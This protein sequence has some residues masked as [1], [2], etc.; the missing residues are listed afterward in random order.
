MA[1]FSL[2]RHDVQA[3]VA[4]VLS[5]AAIPCLL[6][7]MFFVLRPLDVNQRI[8]PYNA[9]GMRP[10]AVYVSALAALSLSAAG[11]GFGLNSVGQRRNDKPGRSW[12]GF[13]VGA[14]GITLTV[15]LLLLFRMW[16]EPIG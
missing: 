16:G 12:I 13:F 10:I 4:M 6:A 7:M 8:I 2:R 1:K 3:Q 5:L 15:I 14:A 11:F 9:K